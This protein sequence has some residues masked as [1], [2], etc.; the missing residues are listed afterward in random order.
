M[1]SAEDGQKIY[2]NGT[3]DEAKACADT[4]T[5]EPSY[6]KFRSR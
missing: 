2:G 3:N 6:T 1:P 4:G 5:H